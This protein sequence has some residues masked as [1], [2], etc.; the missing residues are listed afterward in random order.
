M[1]RSSLRG[2]AALALVVAAIVQE[3]MAPPMTQAYTPLSAGQLQALGG[4]PPWPWLPS[5]VLW[6]HGSFSAMPYP[7]KHVT[8]ATL[9]QGQSEVLHP[10][11]EG[12]I[13]RVGTLKTT[14]T[15]PT[16][17]TVAQGTATVHTLVMKGVPYHYDRVMTMMTTA[18]NASLAMNGP[19]GAVAAWD[20]KPLK[21]G[22]VAVDPRVIPLGS[23]LYIDGYGPARA[24]DTGS[25]I[26]GDHVDLFFNESAWSIGLYG[27]QFHKV[28]V[29][30]TPPPGFKG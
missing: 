27:V 13:L 8:D 23:Y 10:G 11:T 19:S 24:V 2:L 22:D 18:Y 1:H 14:V 20:G 3:V 7:I 28:Y 17:A 29:L 16:P 30:T 25:A 12:T 21:P 15:P 4:I 9:P 6:N 5:G 26:W